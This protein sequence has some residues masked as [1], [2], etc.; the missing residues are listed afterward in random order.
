MAKDD[1]TG[2]KCIGRSGK[3][4][5]GRDI[6]PTMLTQA[7]KNYKP[8]TYK[9]LIWPEH[10]RWINL[11]GIEELRTA[12][13][14]E[15]GID[16][17]AI[18]NPNDYY[19]AFNQ[20]EQKLFSSMELT[21][22]FRGAGEWYLTGS[23][24]TDSPA[25]AGTTEVRFTADSAVK[26]VLYS[27]FTEITDH[28]FNDDQP[29][30]WFTR[31]AEKLHLTKHSD[32]DTM[33]KEAQDALIAKFAAM[34]RDLAALKL[35]KAASTEKPS[36]DY[37]AALTKIEALSAEIETFKSEKTEDAA[38]LLKFSEDFAALQT[39]FKKAVG[40]QNGTDAG[41]HFSAGAGESI[42][43]DC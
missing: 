16:L 1:K 42:Q 26:G 23:A 4:I 10:Y 33:N 41:E 15:G 18:M 17:F 22:N 13:N 6:T 38:K 11:G 29:P 31:F 24:A 30:G 3:T 20:Q 5:D 8:S 37:T 9:A 19:R 28:Q 7:A 34:E 35:E 25:S 32:E 2:W 36:E 40:E 27:T 21:P 12:D 14:D 43:T 39:E